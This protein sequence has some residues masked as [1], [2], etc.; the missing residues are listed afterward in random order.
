MSIR[1]MEPSAT[2]MLP[3][4]GCGNV[5]RYTIRFVPG[6]SLLGS[7]SPI[8]GSCRARLGSGPF[9]IMRRLTEDIMA[10]ALD[11]SFHTVAELELD[12]NCEIT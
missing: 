1:V 4:F 3:G 6:V 12:Q 7:S 9:A 5:T 10:R 8:A 11:D 2:N